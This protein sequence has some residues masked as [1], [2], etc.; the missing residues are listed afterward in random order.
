VD[1]V[2]VKAPGRPTTMVF[3]PARRVARLMDSG[4][5]PWWM[6]MEGILSPTSIAAARREEESAAAERSIRRSV[7]LMIDW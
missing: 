4:G 5:K 2:G 7:A 1:Q 3:L 6:F